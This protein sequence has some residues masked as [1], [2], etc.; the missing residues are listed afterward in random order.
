MAGLGRIQQR[1]NAALVA[2]LALAGFGG[3]QATTRELLTQSGVPLSKKYIKSSN[4]KGNTPGQQYLGYCSG[5][6]EQERRQAQ[7]EAAWNRLY[8]PRYG[9]DDVWGRGR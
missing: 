4:P 8:I 2:V 5:V 7:I 9:R 3:R 1:F 6:Q